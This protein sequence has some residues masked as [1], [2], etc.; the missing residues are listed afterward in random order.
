MWL[1]FHGLNMTTEPTSSQPT[2]HQIETCVTI[3][4]QSKWVMQQNSISR[5]HRHT[6][7]RDKDD[8]LLLYY[9]TTEKLLKSDNKR[10]D[11]QTLLNNSDDLYEYYQIIEREHN[12]RNIHDV[13]LFSKLFIPK[14]PTGNQSG[15]TSVEDVSDIDNISSIPMDSPSTESMDESQLKQLHTRFS[16]LMDASK[17]QSPD[18]P[19]TITTRLGHGITP[20]R[21]NL[22][23]ILEGETSALEATDSENMGSQSDENEV[24]RSLFFDTPS[25]EKPSLSSHI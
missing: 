12:N 10:S 11:S 14:P 24:S 8:A 2:D 17:P 15:K 20:Y 1:D 9:W 16:D 22:A 25:K 23:P 18:S 21:N 6:P 3:Q 5:D 13:A 4:S 7:T 19:S